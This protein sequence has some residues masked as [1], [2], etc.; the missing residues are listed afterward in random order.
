MIPWWW[1][2]QHHLLQVLLVLAY[3]C[4]LMFIK[5]LLLSKHQS[6]DF[7]EGARETARHGVMPRPWPLQPDTLGFVSFIYW[8]CGLGQSPSI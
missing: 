5:Y 3:L 6:E 2:L 4:L 1:G 7:M 8:L